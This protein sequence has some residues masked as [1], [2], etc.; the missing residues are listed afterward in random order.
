MGHSISVSACPTSS[1]PGDQHRDPAMSVTRTRVIMT[2][3][4]GAGQTLQL[5]NRT[6][7]E[8]TPAVNSFSYKKM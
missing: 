7:V 4:R 2:I 3:G 5:G 8:R 6:T 1:T